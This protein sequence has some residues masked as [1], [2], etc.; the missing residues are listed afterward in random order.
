MLKAPPLISSDLHFLVIKCHCPTFD[1]NIGPKFKKSEV[2]N[3]GGI[4]YVQKISLMGIDPRFVR[5]I[6]QI[7]LGPRFVRNITQIPLSTRFVRN[8]TT[9]IGHIA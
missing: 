3:I 4:Q 9:F 1:D 2:C 8:I 6:S 7:S 5:I